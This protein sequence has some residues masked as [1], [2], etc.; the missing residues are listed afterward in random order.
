M[1]RTVKLYRVECKHVVKSPFESET[2]NDLDMAYL[3]IVSKSC[4]SWVDPF[5]VVCISLLL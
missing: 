3:F 4:Q 5:N 2:P 1:N